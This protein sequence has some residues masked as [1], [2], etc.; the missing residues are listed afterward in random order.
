MTA[1]YEPAVRHDWMTDAL[2]AQVDGDLWFPDK[3]SDAS[4]ARRICAQCPVAVQCAE[5]AQ[6][7]GERHGIWGGVSAR[8]LSRMRGAA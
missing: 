7:N 5:L 8:Q 2:C 3:G 6:A 1:A 4:P